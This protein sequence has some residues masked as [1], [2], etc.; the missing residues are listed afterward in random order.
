MYLQVRALE[1]RIPVVAA[2]VCG[3]FFGGRSMVVDFSYNN[4][5]EVAI[6]KTKTA[7]S[8]REELIIV[9]INL[10]KSR[11][12]REKRFGQSSVRHV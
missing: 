9:S 3:G 1:N 6:P 5:T 4:R 8:I 7:S 12:I 11:Q 2:N 10:E